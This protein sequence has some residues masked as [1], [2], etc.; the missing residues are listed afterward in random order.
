MKV[1]GLRPLIICLSATLIFPALVSGPTSAQ[2]Q[3]HFV[4]HK[5]E[6]NRQ[7]VAP[8]RAD[9]CISPAEFLSELVLLEDGRAGGGFGLWEHNRPNGLALYR[10]VEGRAVNPLGPFYEFKARRLSPPSADEI[11]V[12]LRPAPDQTAGGSVRFFIDGLSS[13]GGE[14]L[15]FE[16]SGTVHSHA[17]PTATL[18]DFVIGSFFINAPTQIVLV[19]KRRG[20]DR[21][22]VFASVAMVFPSG[23]AIGFASLSE[24]EGEGPIDIRYT[25]G[26]LNFD[27]EEFSWGFMRGRAQPKGGVA[28]PLPVLLVIADQLD[29]SEPCRIY[30][31]AGW[32]GR[33]VH[34]EAETFITQLTPGR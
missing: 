32:Q 20:N 22:A 29:A 8:L 5:I 9:G 14:P 15:S 33:T 26:V 7:T 31:I 28:R 25:D 17:A 11:T 27:D 18:S 6:F 16:A 13:A 2:E 30:D 4:F 19:A 21:A 3:I 34:F 23:R 24:G 1:F 12:S 10:V